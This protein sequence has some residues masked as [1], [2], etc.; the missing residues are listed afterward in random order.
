MTVGG[1]EKLAAWAIPTDCP[2]NRNNF[3]KVANK[4]SGACLGATLGASCT[5]GFRERLR[6]KAY[7]Q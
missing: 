3:R 5:N 6:H 1:I 4:G 7:G 2:L